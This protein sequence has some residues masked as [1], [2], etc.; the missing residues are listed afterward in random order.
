MTATKKIELPEGIIESDTVRPAWDSKTKMAKG[1][2]GYGV[3]EFQL[4]YTERFG[5]C[6]PTLLIGKARRAGT[7]D[8]TYATTLKGET[9]RIGM[10]PH[11]LATH[12]VY[13]KES[14]LAKLQKFVDI[15]NAWAG[16]AGDIRDRISTR[17]ANTIAHRRGGW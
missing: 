16:R 13:V 12:T 6:I 15:M 10:G 1:P 5:W 8:R 3:L 17:R 9:V 11:V 4:W 7:Q 2:D 14:R